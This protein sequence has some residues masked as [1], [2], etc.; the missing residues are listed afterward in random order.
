MAEATLLIIKDDGIF[1]ARFEDTART[2]DYA[3]FGLTAKQPAFSNGWCTGWWYGLSSDILVPGEGTP[4]VILPTIRD[5][6]A[7]RRSR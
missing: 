7:P 4:A 3:V 6:L 5:T 1:A 2:L